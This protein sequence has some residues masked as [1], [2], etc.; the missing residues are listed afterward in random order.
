MKLIDCRG[1]GHLTIHCQFTFAVTL[2][3]VVTY[4]FWAAERADQIIRGFVEDIGL[5]HVQAR[6]PIYIYIYTF[7]QGDWL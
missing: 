4:Y 2:S 5:F 7:W 6:F 3:V 1:I